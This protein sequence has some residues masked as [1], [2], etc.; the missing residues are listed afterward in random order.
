MAIL[1]ATY[2]GGY[3]AHV[4]RI[5]TDSHLM[6]YIYEVPTLDL[7]PYMGIDPDGN[8][9]VAEWNSRSWVTR[10][11][12]TFEILKTTSVGPLYP[13]M[14]IH[15]IDFDSAGNVY[16]QHRYECSKCSSDGTILETFPTWG[17]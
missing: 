14:H 1:Y 7:G 9:C 8:L 11:P 15:G 4:I 3:G 10:H 2:N 5:N 12:T 13:P 17:S 16:L 6:T